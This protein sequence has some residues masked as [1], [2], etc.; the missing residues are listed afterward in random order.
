MRAAEPEL[1]SH[2]RLSPPS[3]LDRLRQKLAKLRRQFLPTDAELDLDY[4]NESTDLRDLEYRMQ[5]LDQRPR[6]R[7]GLCQPR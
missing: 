5:K 3:A 7:S 6:L 4:L 1:G 2:Q